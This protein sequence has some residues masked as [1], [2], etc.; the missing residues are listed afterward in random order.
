MYKLHAP[1]INQKRNDLIVVRKLFKEVLGYTDDE[2]DYFEQTDFCC[3][4]AINL[5]IEQ[6]QQITQIFSNNDI[7]IY[8]K[9][10]KTDTFLF[11]QNDL[12]VI[13]P[14]NPPRA[15]YCNKPLVSRDHLVNA[16]TEQEMERQHNIQE[17]QLEERE[18]ALTAKTAKVPTCPI[19]KS[20]DL[21]KIS[22]AKKATKIAL[23]GIFGMGDNGKTWKCNNC[24]SKF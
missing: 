8:L 4:V 24:G 18:K 15:H 14:T 3:D 7:H 17:M 20:T 6:A 22:T 13:I 5:T 19:C 11:W 23:F 21:T 12:G 1:M 10:Q 9:D 2:I 16:F